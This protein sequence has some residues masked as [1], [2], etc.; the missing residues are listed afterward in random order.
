MKDYTGHEPHKGEDPYPNH[1]HTFNGLEMYLFG[2][3]CSGPCEHTTAN[4]QSWAY[5]LLLEVWK[6]SGLPLRLDV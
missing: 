5:E 2:C 3:F 6:K 1:P 4:L